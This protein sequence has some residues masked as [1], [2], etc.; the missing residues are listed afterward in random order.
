[1]PGRFDG[2]WLRDSFPE[3]ARSMDRF[4]A[5]VKLETNGEVVGDLEII[6]IPLN[7]YR[8]RHATSLAARATTRSPH[9]R[10]PGRRFGDRLPVLPVDPLGFR[11]RDVP[12]GTHH[13]RTTC[14]STQM[15]D[16][17]E[18]YI[19]KQ[20]LRVY[21]QSKLIKNNK[22]LFQLLDEPPGSS[23]SSHLLGGDIG[24]H[25]S[26]SPFRT[27]PC[28]HTCAGSR[29]RSCSTSRATRELGRPV[30]LPGRLHADLPDR[31]LR[32]R[33]SATRSSSRRAP[34]CSAREHEQLLQPQGLVRD[35]PAARRGPL[36]RDRRQVARA[37]R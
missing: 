12:C 13:G 7:L 28:R 19:Y 17:Y 6:R 27:T 18:R 1:M 37:G 5:K 20:W 3:V 25:E 9:A 23:T 11:V 4:I 21:I 29:P 10:V 16:R 36:S 8:A 15:L 35:R 31:A 34:Y 14:R 24:S 26:A 30:L 32:V 22:D 2:E 33:E